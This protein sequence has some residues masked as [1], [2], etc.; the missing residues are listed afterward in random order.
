[1]NT[2][3]TKENFHSQVLLAGAALLLRSPFSGS[4]S[5][6]QQINHQSPGLVMKCYGFVKVWKA[7]HLLPERKMRWVL[8]LGKLAQQLC[9]RPAILWNKSYVSKSCG[10]F[11]ACAEESCLQLHLKSRTAWILG[12][13]LPQVWWNKL[14]SNT[15][16]SLIFVSP[17]RSWDSNTGCSLVYFHPSPF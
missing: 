10:S 1:M 4:T 11:L 6:L 7:L 13:H 5:L 14:F 17:H 8:S 16:I 12:C 15:G 2:T 3:A 9:Q